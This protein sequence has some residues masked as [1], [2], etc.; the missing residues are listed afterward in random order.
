MSCLIPPSELDPWNAHQTKLLCGPTSSLIFIISNYFTNI[1]VQY[2]KIHT[3][4]RQ[5]ALQTL[6]WADKFDFP[7]F[8]NLSYKSG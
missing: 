5:R 6:A 4:G 7:L 1:R 8:N 3:S 2:L